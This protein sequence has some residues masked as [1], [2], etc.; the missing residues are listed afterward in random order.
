MKTVQG[1]GV[2]N[3]IAFGRLKFYH[4]DGNLGVQRRPAQDAAAEIRRF[5]AALEEVSARLEDLYRQTVSSLGEENAAVFQIH[6]MILEDP[7]FLDAVREMIHTECVCAE[8]AVHK[9]G[10]LL[11]QSFAAMGTVGGD[12]LIN[13]EKWSDYDRLRWYEQEIPQA[14][15]AGAV[16]IGSVGHTLQ[17]ARAIVAD[18]EA[19]GAKMIE[20]VSYT[21]DTLLPMTE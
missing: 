3:G 4:H 16:V 12:S 14:V 11:A 18:V 15:A 10:E 20:L 13:C 8:Y 17:E 21:E 9:T 5:E 19:A 1:Q 2:S 6:Q 7:D